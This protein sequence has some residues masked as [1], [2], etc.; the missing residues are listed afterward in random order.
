MT[1]N[2]DTVDYTLDALDADGNPLDARSLAADWHGGQWSPLYALASSGTPVRGLG[3]EVRQALAIAST[4]EDRDQLAA[5]AAWAV[6]HEPVPFDPE[7]VEETVIA[8]AVAALDH[9]G[10]TV[11]LAPGVTLRLTVE[12][13]CDANPFECDDY[14]GTIVHRDSAPRN[15]YGRPMRPDGFDGNAEVIQLGRSDFYWWQPPADAPR[16]GT[17]EW[18]DF[19][20]YVVELGEYGY[21]VVIVDVEVGTDAVGRPIIAGRGVLGGVDWWVSGNNGAEGMDGSVMRDVVE[22][23]LRDAATGGVLP[24]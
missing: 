15:E 14:L 6:R 24:S 12:P 8:D 23:A 1:L 4:D 21:A 11:E 3:E 2:L 17:P 22:D 7:D 5:L 19:R 10:A 16:R 9:D 18:D 20:R 13:D